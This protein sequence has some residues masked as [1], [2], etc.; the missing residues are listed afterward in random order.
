MRMATLGEL[1]VAFGEATVGQPLTLDRNGVCELAF[2]E[3]RRLTLEPEPGSDKVH[4]YSAVAPLPARDAAN[5]YGKLLTANLFGSGTGEAWFAVDPTR[6]MVVLNRILST[7]HMDALEFG[8]LVT[9]FMDV[10]EHWGRELA[11]P[12]FEQLDAVEEA[13]AAALPRGGPHL[14]I[15]G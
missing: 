3:G 9:G 8:E 4:L 12:G 10:V 7:T 13:A 15:R 6:E 11:G 2:H 14:I 5:V 1:L